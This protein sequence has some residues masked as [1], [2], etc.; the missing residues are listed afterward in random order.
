M[1]GFQLSCAAMTEPTAAPSSAPHPQEDQVKMVTEEKSNQN[2]QVEAMG[3]L[4][5]ANHCQTD[6]VVEIYKS[7]H[8]GDRVSQS[9]RFMVAINDTDGNL[10]LCYVDPRGKLHHYYTFD[11]GNMDHDEG[12][13]TGDAFVAYHCKN[14]EKPATVSDLHDNYNCTI[15]CSYRVRLA[16]DKSHVHCVRYN[17]TSDTQVSCTVTC[18]P[19]RDDEYR[20]C[21]GLPKK[22]CPLP[23]PNESWQVLYE[24]VCPP[25]PTGS[26]WNKH[27]HTFYVWGDLDFD[28]YG[29]S[30]KHE[31]Q[32]RHV[33]PC[34]MNQ[35]VPQVMIGNCLAWSDDKYKPSWIAFDRWVIQAQYYWQAH[36]NDSKAYCGKYIYV[37]PGDL[38][39]TRICYDANDGSIHVSIAVVMADGTD[40]PK[41]RS[42]VVIPRP[43]LHD[44]S[45]FTN[46]KDFFEKCL[47]AE[48]QEEKK[49]PSKLQR[50]LGCFG[51]HR[52][53]PSLRATKPLGALARPCLNVEYKGRVDIETLKSICP[54]VIKKAT[55]PSLPP[56]STS[57]WNMHLY[58][59]RTGK[60]DVLQDAETKN[61]LVLEDAASLG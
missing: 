11:K 34:Y 38:I 54:F 23:L 51:G 9:L 58:C 27:T 15:L 22:L 50:L 13:Y 37:Q 53:S 2:V 57:A 1:T 52:R 33:H 16:L 60:V 26:T 10:V 59:P 28:D 6:T 36:K 18:I 56:N 42:D 30:H 4:S 49:A 25:L 8:S 3:D 39:R 14:K 40:D 21:V 5:C 20:V 46:W 19:K 7:E 43:F 47:A 35:I 55:Y 24:Y 29:D 17:M 12:T 31:A 44:P 45:L 61:S 32:L 48:G 41:K